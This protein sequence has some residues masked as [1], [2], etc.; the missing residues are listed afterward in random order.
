MSSIQKRLA[1]K[2]SEALPLWH[3]RWLEHP[4]FLSWTSFAHSLK[5][6]SDNPYSWFLQSSEV[7]TKPSA[8]HSGSQP[9]FIETYFLASQAFWNLSWRLPDPTALTVCMHLKPEP[10]GQ[11]LC[12]MPAGTEA[13][14]LYLI[15]FNCLDCWVLWIQSWDRYSLGCC[16][17]GIF[18]TSKALLSK[19]SFTFWTLRLKIVES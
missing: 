2:A 17:L 12:L 10:C 1:P 3:Y 9:A 7:S 19:Q 4:W 18:G 13:R 15:E 11:C 8:S 5:L 6:F 14:F 16:H